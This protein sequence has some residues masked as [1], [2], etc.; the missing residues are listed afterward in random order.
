MVLQEVRLVVLCEEA[1]Q[2]N[3]FELIQFIEVFHCQP[4]KNH[5]VHMTENFN[6]KS[7]PTGSPALVLFAEGSWCLGCCLLLIDGETCGLSPWLCVAVEEHPHIDELPIVI[8]LE[9]LQQLVCR[10][11]DFT[12][13]AFSRLEG[14]QVVSQLLF[15]LL[16][17]PTYDFSW[18]GRF[19]EDR[20]EVLQSG[21]TLGE[22]GHAL[23]HL[24]VLLGEGTLP[25][26]K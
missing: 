9:T 16:K 17:A 19:E 15:S 7:L 11:L 12:R 1:S 3:V 2:L 22:A 8:A 18:S 13:V 6:K 26:L 20:F 10:C 4:E 23:Q 24:G 21:L 25:L 14:F 5:I